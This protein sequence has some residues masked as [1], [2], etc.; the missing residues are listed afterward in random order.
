MA[1]A[2]GSQEVSGR[3]RSQELKLSSCSVCTRHA[4]DGYICP[5]S[6][7]SESGTVMDRQ[8]RSDGISGSWTSGEFPN[9]MPCFHTVNGRSDCLLTPLGVLE[10]E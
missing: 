8:A 3:E 7:V 4:P 9:R 6:D 5:G 2:S 10:L 1:A